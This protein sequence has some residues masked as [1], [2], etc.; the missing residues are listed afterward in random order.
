MDL[1]TTTVEVKTSKRRLMAQRIVI[2][3]GAATIGAFVLAHMDL[4]ATMA[5]GVVGSALL[6]LGSPKK[7]GG[8]L[9][10]KWRLPVAALFLA[11]PLAL[12]ATDALKYRQTAVSMSE[13]YEDIDLYPEDYRLAAEE[14]KD[15]FD[16]DN[17][18]L[19]TSIDLPENRAK[20][21]T[22]LM[23]FRAPVGAVLSGELSIEE[24][25]QVGGDLPVADRLVTII[26]DGLSDVVR[27][28]NQLGVLYCW[29]DEDQVVAVTPVFS[30]IMEADESHR[31]FE[32]VEHEGA[33][34]N[35]AR[36]PHILS[37]FDLSGVEVLA[38]LKTVCEAAV[39][40]TA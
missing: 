3:A 7:P 21:D 14:F 6:A 34:L 33:T 39:K 27:P 17:L 35:I 16:S 20:M 25:R 13:V 10:L 31:R 30:V 32:K 40:R 38:P 24:A 22:R 1:P 12:Y 5:C 19:L 36:P 15:R 26:A 28:Y 23:S 8:G 11:S 29:A 2:H 4:A 18:G 9:A 37:R